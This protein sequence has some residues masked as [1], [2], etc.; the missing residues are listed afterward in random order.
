MFKLNNKITFILFTI[1]HFLVDGICAL[2]IFSYLVVNQDTTSTTII[3]LIY[4]F[5][6]FLTQPFIGLLIDK[7]KNKER[8]FLFISILFLFFGV[9]LKNYSIIA[10]ILLG[11]GNSFFHI[12]GGKYVICH[13][14]NIIDIGV[15]VSTGALGLAIGCNYTNSYLLLITLG[16]IF[17][18]SSII[19]FSKDSILLSDK[20]TTNQKLDYKMV[21]ILLS[22]VCICVFIR[23]FVGK[24]PNFTFE[25]TK[26]ILVL[27]GL[28]STLGKATG[29]IISK[30]FGINKT[31]ILTMLLSMILL[32]FG[33][34][35]LYLSL[36][37]ILLFN[38]SMPITLYLANRIIKYQGFAFGMLAAFLIPGYL[39]GL[40]SFNDIIIKIL[41]I[42]LSIISVILVIIVNK[43]L[44]KK[45]C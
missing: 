36:L 43:R 28:A 10:S 4:N 30:I 11:I 29:G 25:K 19:I 34:N 15:F 45:E 6:A 1:L 22:L 14:N 40:Y 27:F 41:I 5:L 42:T 31:I 21:F 12:S 9:I 33:N 7:Y 8:L 26:L 23:S 18:I 17:I 13:T 39:L 16:L 2:T 24:I 37:G 32:S 20:V 3:L 44:E 35:N 38:T